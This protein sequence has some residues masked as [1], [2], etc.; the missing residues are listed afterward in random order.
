MKLYSFTIKI[1]ES[2]DDLDVVDAFY[3]QVD[4][5]SISGSRGETFIHFDREAD[6]LD[7]ALNSA[8]SQV[9]AEGWHVAEIS[10]EPECLI[11]VSSP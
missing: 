10:V 3:G 9:L 2:L 8:L 5:A 4:D 1:D 11:P 7:N 6:S